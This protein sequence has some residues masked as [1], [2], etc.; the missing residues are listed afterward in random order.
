MSILEDTWG[1][2]TDF[3]TLYSQTISVNSNNYFDSNNDDYDLESVSY[4][5]TNPIINKVTNITLDDYDFGQAG[6]THV[7]LEVDQTV[8]ED[9]GRGHHIECGAHL[10]SKFN[11]PIQYFI[12]HPQTTLNQVEN[13]TFPFIVTPPYA[14]NYEFRLRVYKNNAYVRHSYFTVTIDPE[15]LDPPTYEFHQALE[16][17]TQLYPNTNQYFSISWTTINYLPAG[18]SY[19]EIT[20]DNFFTL[21]SKYCVLTTNATG[22]DG[23]GIECEI[24]VTENKILLQHLAEMNGG[25]TFQLDLELTSTSTAGSIS[26]TVSI[27]SYYDT[28]KIVDTISSSPL[29][30][31]TIS[32]TNLETFT[33]FDIPN[34]QTVERRPSKGYFGHLLFKFKPRLSSSVGNGDNIIFTF[35]SEFYP[36]SNQTNLPMICQINSQRYSCTYSLNPFVVTFYDVDNGFSSSSENDIN[37]TT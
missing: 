37:I 1:Y 17:D 21:A 28:D 7:I 2:Q 3:I 30:T 18:T 20:L 24:W 5:L 25:T 8:F 33:T 29:S 31:T 15:P 11:K 27:T 23:R 16:T 26:P 22:V 9:I 4:T 10:C 36:Y 19:F 34:P 14:G 13:L 12:L 32:N 35:T 6:V